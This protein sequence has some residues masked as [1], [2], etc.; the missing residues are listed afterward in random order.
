M[1]QIKVDCSKHFSAVQAKPESDRGLKPHSP[2]WKT[3]QLR[4]FS[5]GTEIKDGIRDDMEH[6]VG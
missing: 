1:P 5:Q 6:W 2:T 3:K 4:L